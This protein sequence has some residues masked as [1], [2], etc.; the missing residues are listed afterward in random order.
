M[1]EKSLTLKDL[2]GSITTKSTSGERIETV[3]IVGGG[4]MGRGIAQALSTHGLTVIIVE[5]DSERAQHTLDGLS[6]NMDREIKRW[7]MTAS[8]KR[9]I[10]SRIKVTTDIEAI[11]GVDFA[12]EAVDE[13]FDL[14]RD[15]LH[16][17]D[18]LCRPDTIIASNTSTLSLTKMVRGTTNPKKIIGLHFSYPV[19]K[20]PLCE[21]VRAFETSDDTFQRTK[22]FIQA[23]GKTPVEV[24]EYPGF[25]TTRV[26]IP[27]LNEA[28]YILMEGVA[29]AEDIDTAMRLG[30]NFQMGPLELADSMG[31][32]ELLAM[33][34]TMFHEFGETKYRPC[35]LLRRLVREQKYGKKSG[36]GFF[37]YDESG[38]RIRPKNAI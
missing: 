3:G 6:E 13:Q 24:Y 28:M 20:T 4:V 27:M 25:I 7:A 31:L 5:R 12:M 2:T 38:N 33:M 8:E 15:V 26:I 9:A 29:S 36:Q 22:A 14:K 35:P 32:E 30:F 1:A 21:I 37:R 19:P 17:L 16:T 10:L 23:I 34:E 11:A 18:K